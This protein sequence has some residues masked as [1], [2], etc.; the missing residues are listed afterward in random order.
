VSE[1]EEKNKALV[2]RFIEAQDKGDLQ[3]LDELFAPDFIDHSLLPDQ[4]PGREG[5]MRAV[6]E[7]LAS[8]SAT[9]TTIDFQATDGDMVISRLT[10]HSIHDRGELWGKAPTGQERK[11]TAILIHRS[12][13]TRS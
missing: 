5:Y 13:G 3:T 9:H 6:A 10:T 11:T 2:R 4:E 1:T 8:F 7:V 12:P